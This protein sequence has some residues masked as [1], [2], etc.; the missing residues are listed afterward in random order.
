M[1]I[2]KTAGEEVRRAL[3]IMTPYPGK[4]ADCGTRIVAADWI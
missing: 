2:L 3:S 4:R 1:P